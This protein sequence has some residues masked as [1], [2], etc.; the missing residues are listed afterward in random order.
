MLGGVVGGLALEALARA[1]EVGIQVR[2]DRRA[3]RI[4]G[5]DRKAKRLAGPVKSGKREMGNFRNCE[6]LL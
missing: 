2:R 5:R 1:G 3:L 6:N 4:T